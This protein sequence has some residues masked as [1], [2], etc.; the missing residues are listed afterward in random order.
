MAVTKSTATVVSGL[1][2]ALVAP[3]GAA[4]LDERVTPVGM[5]VGMLAVILAPVWLVVTDHVAVALVMLVGP[6]PGV[7]VVTASV[8]APANA[9]WLIALIEKVIGCVAVNCPRAAGAAATTRTIA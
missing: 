2:P 3:A 5:T 4:R 6:E 8:G 9:I 1:N 7:A